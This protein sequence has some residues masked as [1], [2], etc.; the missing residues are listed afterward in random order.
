MPKISVLMPVYNSEK[1]LK[2]AVDSILSQTFED[3]EFLMLYDK[4]TDKSL[5]IINSYND[6][7]IKIINCN[8]KGLVNALN[9]GLDQAKGDF[10]ARMDSDDIS[11]PERF[12]KQIDFLE[13]NPNVGICGSW[14][15]EFGEVPSRVFKYP[16]EPE[17]VKSKLFFFCAL[18]HPS[19]MMRKN[20]L[21]KHNLRYSEEQKQAEDYEFWQR[22][23]FY[24][25]IANIPE[26]LLK[27]R[28]T[29]VSKVQSNMSQMKEIL[30]KMDRRNL[31]AMGINPTEDE[32][33]LHQAICPLRLPPMPKDKDFV[34]Q[35]E[36]WLLKL[37]SANT[38]THRYPEK[39]FSELIN[40]RWLVV[41]S[42]YI[43][44]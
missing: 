23:S 21:D 19:V 29:S 11:L 18:A 28:I 33:E 31:E 41:Q 24:F 2:E 38:E 14:T 20:Y 15:E 36:K 37:N 1:Y 7:R 4:S 30:K 34:V 3:F 35:A 32:L 44:G 26:A 8:S 12:Q 22:C 5:E 27:Y 6:N 42:K 16:C 10:I 17:I 40:E 43:R 39:I 25:D 13:K 9:I